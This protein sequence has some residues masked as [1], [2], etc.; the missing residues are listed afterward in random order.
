[1]S[2]QINPLVW[3]N[4]VNT[5]MQEDKRGTAQNIAFFSTDDE[6]VVG[7][8]DPR[9]TKLSYTP[10]NFFR[11]HD[12]SKF[13]EISLD[14]RW[15]LTTCDSGVSVVLEDSYL[16][17]ITSQNGVSTHGILNMP[18]IPL[19]FVSGQRMFTY[20]RTEP[21]GNLDLEWGIKQ[22]SNNLIRIRRTDGDAAGSYYG[23]IIT[24]GISHQTTNFLN[25]D[26]VRRMFGI[27]V[28]DTTVEFFYSDDNGVMF[29]GGTVPFTPNE[30]I[31]GRAY[32]KFTAQYPRQLWVDDVYLVRIK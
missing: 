12:H 11:P 18:K 7:P 20:L 10:E 24:N 16:K 3:L 15:Q 26:D 2:N 22:D 6:I 21:N 25:G 32:I 4:N 28:G 29:S 8:T 27:I 13:D 14:P 31:M 5:I 9:F 17:I 19:P 23:E 30:A 1:M